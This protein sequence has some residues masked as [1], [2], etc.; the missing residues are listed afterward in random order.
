MIVCKDCGYKN[1]GSDSFCGSCG[2]FLEWSGERV[3]R[4]KPAPTP[5]PEPEAAPAR[6]GLLARVQSLLYVDVGHR[7]PIPRT[8]PG[9]G[10]RL[11]GPP[12][13]AGGSFGAAKPLGGA[14]PAVPPPPGGGKPVV[15][16]PPPGG[17]TKPVVPP[18]PPGAAAKPLVPPPPPGGATKPIVPPPPPPSGA[19]KPFVPPPPG[20]SRT[21]E[22][23]RVGALVAP[24]SAESG[25]AAPP[26]PATGQ[27]LSTMP[28]R[29]AGGGPDV[30]APQERSRARLSV[31]RSAP[32]RELQPGDLVCGD[33]GEGNLSTRRFCSRCGNELDD[34]EVVKAKWWRRLLP[35]RKP[36]AAR[37]VDPDNGVAKTGERRKH[38]RSIFPI[39]R[40]AIA[41]LILVAG[42]A[43]AAIPALRVR[44]NAEA[45]ALRQ[46]VEKM[47]F[48]TPVPVRAVKA[49]STPVIRKYPASLAVDGHWNTHWMTPVSGA[50]RLTLTFPEPVELHRAL[51]R[52][53]IVGDLRGSQRP[54]T[55]HLVYP[56]GKGQDL[57]L[58]DM[59]DPQEFDLD[60]DGKVKSLE[61]YVQD[62]YPNAESRHI[63][64]TEIELFTEE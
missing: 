32:T 33:C 13:G 59:T 60:S 50:R 45:L 54:K 56:T 17:A 24:L 43:Y 18:P 25:P 9:I 55:L 49:T 28:V 29:P 37:A 58:I 15:P 1:A 52:G 40:Q 6:K 3:E 38:K 10:S 26:Q 14:K 27:G 20:S 4:P 35:K 63:A 53:G 8:S 22:E 42:I 12:G 30:V 19:A 11:P 61:V 64:I 23:P 2:A 47:I 48:G 5:E 62:T 36:R 31:Q 44:T 34:A 51:I 21:T 46:R 7:D 16:P 39:V 41:V 57:K